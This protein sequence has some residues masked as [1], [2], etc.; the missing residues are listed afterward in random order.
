MEYLG[1]LLTQQ[2]CFRI[3]WNALGCL[4]ECSRPPKIATLGSLKIINFG[5]PERPGGVKIDPQR[6]L[7]PILE[8]L[9]LLEASWSGLGGLLE[10][11]WTA[12]G[13][14]KSALE[15]LLAAPR[16]IPREVSAILKAKRLPKR[17]PGGSQ[18]GSRRRLQL[19]RAKSQNLEDV[20]RNSLIFK[21]PG[22]PF[23]SKNG[24]KTGSQS[25][26]RR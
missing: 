1:K 15:R 26:H 11:S 8:P 4:A 14:E 5:V 16:G 22:P 10:R 9:Q 13:L 19:K 18:I 2:A 6:R 24:T 3:S 7:G 20:S 23:G 12:L 25:Q 21:V 17:S